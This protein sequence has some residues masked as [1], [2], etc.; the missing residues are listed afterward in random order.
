M[1]QPVR[2]KATEDP[3]ILREDAV[4]FP[5]GTV[6]VAV[7]VTAQRR[8]STTGDLVLRAFVHDK[9]IELVIPGRRKAAAVPLLQRLQAKVQYR[10][11]LPDMKSDPGDIRQRLRV[12]GAWRVRLLDELSASPGRRFQLV[13][14]RWRY[15]DTSGVEQVYG[16]L[17]GA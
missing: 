8:R 3:F 17:P 6:Q 10:K 12:D 13:A 5:S 16:Q 11:L 2:Q 7:D 15:S 14:A 9:E 4:Q 1:L